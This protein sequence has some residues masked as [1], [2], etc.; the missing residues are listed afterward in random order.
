MAS[1]QYV[2][3]AVPQADVGGPTVLIFSAD[4]PAFSVDINTPPLT[5]APR[6]HLPEGNHDLPGSQAASMTETEWLACTDPRPMLAF[7]LGKASDRKLRLFAVACCRRIGDRL[8]GEGVRHAVE[9][10]EQF[11]DG[12]ASRQQLQSARKMAL[13]STGPA[14]GASAAACAYQAACYAADRSAWNAAEGAAR[15]AR[16]AA[17][18]VRRAARRGAD[19]EVVAGTR[20]ERSRERELAR[21]GQASLLRD[22]FGNPSGALLGHSGRANPGRPSSAEPRVQPIVG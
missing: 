1:P 22:V 5:W 7:L 13:E 16:F 14:S 2:T 11:A 6:L 20:R 18:P 3:M 12:L 15:L 21:Q 19:R 8:E 10:A 9:M 17:S 4:G